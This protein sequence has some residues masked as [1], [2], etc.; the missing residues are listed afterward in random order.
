MSIRQTAVASRELNAAFIEAVMGTEKGKLVPLE[1]EK[2]SIG[3]SSEA[4]IVVQADGVSRIHAYLVHAPE[5]WFI[6][7]NGSKNGIQING[8]PV[9]EAWLQTGDI[10]QVGTF[11]FRFSDPGGGD[12]GAGMDAG[13]NDPVMADFAGSGAMDPMAM[14][15]GMETG[16][17]PKKKPN[18]RVLLY[19]VVGLVLGG[20]FYMNSMETDPNAASSSSSSATTAPMAEE[21][22]QIG[23]NLDKTIQSAEKRKIALVEVQKLRTELRDIE[24]K[25][26]NDDPAQKLE[27]EEQDALIEKRKEVEGKL[28]KQMIDLSAAEEP[29]MQVDASKWADTGRQQKRL[30]GLDDPSLKAA[31]QEMAKLDWSNGS[32]REAEQFFKRGQREYMSKN[33]GRAIDS[34]S[35]ALALYRGHVLADRYLRRTL[36]EVENEARKQ[37]ELGVQYFSS[38]QYQRAMF[39]FSEVSSLM[40]HR[41]TDPMVSEAEK[42]VTLCRKALQAAELFP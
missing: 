22:D 28:R 25:L 30:E 27:L 10:V 23:Q 17:P 7:D 21:G 1:R 35:T 38:L 26:K 39:H 34:F 14:A 36:Y 15:P 4:D 41:T 2:L 31:E 33:Y 20:V 3:R 32:L 13:S 12:A 37:M 24:K 19:A 16:A 40:Q 6:R 42:Y 9:Q 11:V 8:S 5:G 18:R 29:D